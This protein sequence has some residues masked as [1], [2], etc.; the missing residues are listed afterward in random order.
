MTSHQNDGNDARTQSK[1]I[2]QQNLVTALTRFSYSAFQLLSSIDDV[3]WSALNLDPPHAV[4]QGIRRV[5]IFS[6][7]SAMAAV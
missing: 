5:K 3:L 2:F 1:A 6:G 4:K 7:I